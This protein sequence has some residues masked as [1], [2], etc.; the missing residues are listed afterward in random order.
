MQKT[1]LL[2]W[3]PNT[4]LTSKFIFQHHK[5]LCS[6]CSIPLISFLNFKSNVLVKRA[7]LFNSAFAMRTY[8]DLVILGTAQHLGFLTCHSGNWICFCHNNWAP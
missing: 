8:V 6:K 2:M 5:K 3:I 4:K 1:E 7:F